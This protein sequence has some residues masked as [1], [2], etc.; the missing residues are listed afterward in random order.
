[1]T[2]GGRTRQPVRR[3]PRAAGRRVRRA[4]CTGTR[5]SPRGVL[6]RP[7]LGAEQVGHRRAGVEVGVEA[8]ERRARVAP[9]E[10]GLVRAQP[11]LGRLGRDRAARARSWP[12]SGYLVARH[13]PRAAGA[14]RARPRARRVEVRAVAQ[15]DRL[16][17]S[18]NGRLSVGVA[19]TST[20]TRPRPAGPGSTGARARA[21]AVRMPRRLRWGPVGSRGP[22]RCVRPSSAGTIES[23]RWK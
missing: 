6:L 13:L 4:R 2:S 18:A 16:P 22:D 7:V 1:M 17:S 14:R 10:P 15:R 3:P 23:T 21:G 19:R 11:H 9:P 12:A 5:A 8:G 20:Q